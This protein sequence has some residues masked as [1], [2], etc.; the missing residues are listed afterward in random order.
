MNLEAI[1]RNFVGRLDVRRTANFDLQLDHLSDDRVRITQ[2]GGDAWPR[3]ARRRGHNQRAD[4]RNDQAQ[5]ITRSTLKHFG[6]AI[7]TNPYRHDAP[8]CVHR[9]AP[10]ALRPSSIA[11][12]PAPASG[13]SG[14][15]SAVPL[16]RPAQLWEV[17]SASRRLRPP[18]CRSTVFP[19][20]NSE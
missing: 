16:Q 19:A 7:P 11:T 1:D 13:S 5:K 3:R 15:P 6:G 10:A 8:S 12:A 17:R 4:R 9:A 18:L 20:K 2:D 14:L